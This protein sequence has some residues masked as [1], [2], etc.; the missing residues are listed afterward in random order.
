MTQLQ[1]LRQANE[2]DLARLDTALNAVSVNRLELVA[3]ASPSALDTNDFPATVEVTVTSETNKWPE[4]DGLRVI[5]LGSNVIYSF[6]PTQK[7]HRISIP[8]T[9]QMQA[10][11]RLVTA[12]SSPTYKTRLPGGHTAGQRRASIYGL[13][14]C[15]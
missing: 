12:G 11:A 14:T 15:L 2:D 10:N 9:P 5:L 6:D 3:T 8:I 4:A 13:L 7:V 1:R